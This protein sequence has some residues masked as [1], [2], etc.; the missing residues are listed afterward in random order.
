MVTSTEWTNS[1]YVKE[2][3]AKQFVEQ[4]LDSGFWSKCVDVEKLTEPLVRVLCMVDNEDKPAMDFLY[5][6]M[7]K[8]RK[9]MVKMFRR[10][11]MKMEPY[12]KILDHH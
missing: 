9:E 8:A 1:T 12:L 6:A 5:P 11:K 7:Y 3:K 4:V 2:A 10:N